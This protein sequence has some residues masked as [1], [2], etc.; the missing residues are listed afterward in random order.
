MP[1]GNQLITLI[2]S[3]YSLLK[4]IITV[5]RIVIYVPRRIKTV[6][7]HH[8]HVVLMDPKKKTITHAKPYPEKPS[9]SSSSTATDDGYQLQP[10][11][12]DAHQQQYG[13]PLHQQ[14][15]HQHSVTATG[16]VGHPLSYLEQRK[17]I[18][19]G[20]PVSNNMLLYQGQTPLLHV[21]AATYAAWPI[22]RKRSR[23]AARLLVTHH[24]I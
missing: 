16:I 21:P 17:T 15:G 1:Q 7:H 4:I 3:L 19:T 8:H 24:T 20:D 6:H 22:R 23:T 13:Q 9:S 5:Y 2:Y 12:G 18:R 14:Y 10:L 11:D